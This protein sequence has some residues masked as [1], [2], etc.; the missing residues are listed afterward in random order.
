MI[1]AYSYTFHISEM[2]KLTFCND[3]SYFAAAFKKMKDQKMREHMKAFEAQQK[4][5]AALKKSGK[6]S[7]QATEEIKNRLQTKQN[8]VTKG[9]KSSAT[10]GDEGMHMFF[11]F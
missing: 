11:G 4:Q 8:K 6:S 10:M 7:K 9:K 5:L 3:C 2:R 1:A